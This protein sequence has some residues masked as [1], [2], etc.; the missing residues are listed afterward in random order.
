MERGHGSRRSARHA[1][2][3][4]NS[5]PKLCPGEY[6]RQARKGNARCTGTLGSISHVFPP[7]C[8]CYA[9]MPLHQRR[10]PHRHG[11]RR[12][13]TTIG[14]SFFLSSLTPSYSR[15]LHLLKYHPRSANTLH[16][17][18]LLPHFSP[19]SFPSPEQIIS[20]LCKNR[21]RRRRSRPKL[22]RRIKRPPLRRLCASRTFLF[23]SNTAL[24]GVPIAAVAPLYSPPLHS[25]VSDRHDRRS[26][27]PR[28]GSQH[29]RAVCAPPTCPPDRLRVCSHPTRAKRRPRPHHRKAPESLLE[30]SRRDGVP[31]ILAR[32]R[33]I[34]MAWL[35]PSDRDWPWFVIVSSSSD[36][37]EERLFGI[38]RRV[39]CPQRRILARGLLSP[40]PLLFLL[41]PRRH[42]LH[43]HL[44]CI[45]Q[46]LVRFCH[47][48][49]ALRPGPRGDGGGR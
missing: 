4:G 25:S 11:L 44:S 2:G 22:L 27:S 24:C 41:G 45:P 13:G 47:S 9:D 31:P 28:V 15:I 10:A 40:L 26:I 18:G 43:G 46:S 21:R 1:P 19:H 7:V 23:R 20:R 29:D 33:A 17:L 38:S 42:H 16:R 8:S 37:C 30:C 32:L 3:F 14:P 6:K 49:S 35:R 39:D 48:L 36:G 12:V 34:F 5:V